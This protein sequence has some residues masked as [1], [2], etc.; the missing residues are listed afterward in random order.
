MK[1]PFGPFFFLF[2]MIIVKIDIGDMMKK[3][4]CL[5]VVILLIG[6]AHEKILSEKKS[7]KIAVASDLHYFA[8]EYY[9]DCEWFEESMLY[10]DGKM[11]T[12]ADEIID[13]F[14][15]EM[16]V[17]KIDLVVLTGDLTFNGEVNSHKA[18]ASKLNRLKENHINVAV[19]NGNH[20]VGNI[21]AKGY[22][23][24]DYF[25]VDNIDGKEFKEIYKDLGYDLSINQHSDSLSYEIPLNDHY[26]LILVD[27]N[28]HEMTGALLDTGGIISEPTKI[29]LKESLDKAKDE[30]R[31][32]IIAMHHNLGV[33]NEYM[34]S[35]YTINN[36][37][38]ITH[39]FKSYDI[40]LVLSGHIH[41]QDILDIEG[42]KEVTSSSLLN[43]PLQYGIVE[44]K[45]NQIHYQT[46]SLK[47]N[48]D[49]NQ[50]FNTVSYNKFYQDKKDEESN[51]KR[52]VM[53][54]ANNHY[55]AGTINKVKN[56]IIK[57]PGYPLILK[58]KGFNLQYLKS[59]LKNDDNNTEITIQ[60]KK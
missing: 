20:D 28:M 56:K 51:L 14:I 37:K 39:L 36:H 42:I 33:H 7:L 35:G 30:N 34:N 8:K 47:I 15:D 53:V 25:D 48:E 50:Y 5:L 27:T 9:Q 57:M 16:I 22:G 3:I 59:M 19:I 4:L 6:C 18:L 10:G 11:V 32:P 24:D 44:L 21:Y 13:K 41:L 60:L 54:L 52:D 17:Q 23:K 38:D 46:H 29:W 2:Y 31:I 43:N 58:E 49:S 12:F 45:E 40:P 26:T 1:G 55:F